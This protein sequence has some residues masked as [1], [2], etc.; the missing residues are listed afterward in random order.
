MKAADIIQKILCILLLGLFLPVLFCVCF[1]G[2]AMPYWGSMKLVT[3]L[4]D[5]ILFLMAL[6]G[7][8]VCIFLFRKFAGGELTRRGNWI[9]NGVLGLLFFG[10]YF[11]NLW[12][13]K[14]IC[15][16]LNADSMV[17]S[18]VAYEYVHE[19]KLGDFYYLSM[20]SNNIP[21]GYLLGRLL[22]VAVNMQQYPYPIHE[23]IWIQVNCILFSIAGFFCCLTVKRMTKRL[24]P[25]AASFL[26]Y[27]AVVGISPRKI[28]P[29]TDTYG[30]VFPII[31]L[32]CYV[33][34][35]Q[36]RREW[37]KWA[38]L[39]ASL[40]A[41]M[42]GG[43]V[44]PSIYIVVIAILGAEGIGFLKQ[45]KARWRFLLAELVLAGS[46]LYGNRL[47]MDH[48]ISELGLNFNEEIEAGWQ[49]YFLMGL[50]EAT[51]G[52]YNAE[53]AA[54]FG[55][56][57]SSRDDRIHAELERAVGR[58]KDRGAIGSLSFYLRKMAMVFNDGTFNWKTEYMG[59]QEYPVD[60]SSKTPLTERLRSIFWSN[61]QGYD[62]GGYN[63]F[64]QLVWLFSLIGI[65][66]ICM[67]GIRRE[68]NNI[69]VIA[70]LGIF[71]YQMLFEAR[72]RYLF[73]FL[74][75]ILVMSICGIWEY[76]HIH[77][78]KAFCLRVQFPKLRK[79]KREEGV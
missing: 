17:V 41:G 79:T 56:F 3:R 36:A 63:T 43:L 54:M 18:G 24:L 70:F 73:V 6:A 26:L 31:S 68:E 46:L 78:R 20:Y 22:R 39:S 8:G 75:V 12:I 15:F 45:Y 33:C 77:T 13:A 38:Y 35:R 40:I 30:M 72:A 32:Y 60:L 52:G 9:T 57:Q 29:Y 55:E 49:H 51:T 69:F 28:A 67:G 10:L 34:Y 5:Q 14:E 58:L 11:L 74:P 21:I 16:L 53:D 65:P 62:V 66:G 2:N 37:G 59:D 48:M 44:K 7:V 47:C 27:V 25:V 50:N 1:I 71:L 19:R 4:P 61:E 64:C 76:A 42:A 23:F